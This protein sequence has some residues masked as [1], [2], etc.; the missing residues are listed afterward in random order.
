V[1]LTKS[2]RIEE[3]WRRGLTSWKLYPDQRELYDAIR[4]FL[5]DP[6]TSYGEFFV[7]VC[8]QFG[9]TFTGLLIA[10]E[11]ARATPRL[12]LLYTCATRAALWQ[13]VQPNMQT[14]L[15]DCP[16]DLKP[17][18]STVEN[19]YRYA[20]GS[21][22]HLCGVN[23][24]HEDEARGPKADYIFNEEAAFVDR[25]KYLVESVERPMLTTTGGRIVYITTQ[26]ESQD[27]HIAKICASCEAKGRYIKR[28]LNDVTHLS[29]EAKD[30]LIEES[31]GRQST[32]VRREFF[33][34]RIT[35]RERAII[36]EFTDSREGLI[37]ERERPRYWEAYEVMDPGFSPSTTAVLFGY[38]DLRAAVYVIEDELVVSQM[39]M[40]ALVDEVRRKEEALW[41]DKMRDYWDHKKN[42]MTKRCE[43][44][45][46]WSDILPVWLNDLASYGLEFNQT[47]KDDLEAQIN[48]VRIWTKQRKYRIHPRC[49]SLIAQLSAGVWNKSR[50]DFELSVDFG[51]YDAISALIYGVRNCPVTSN[52][53]PVLPEDVTDYTHMI[54]PWTRKKMEEHGTEAVRQILGGLKWT[55][56]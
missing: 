51:H 15:M 8:R 55:A 1:R 29:Q 48:K 12:R 33:C 17:Q 23:N 49:K 5:A 44:K 3:L 36:P 50:T 24:G 22:I 34:E 46:R 52:P 56:T 47:A 7:D 21:V 30:A 43:V 14:L 54:L 6:A 4:A 42:V 9:K 26:P 40:D 39:L 53:Y 19:S 45:H 38:Y 18:W 2:E 27:H 13:F 31:G 16:E 28:T 20:N 11:L 32:N 10:D 41:P 37:E 25:L 35:E